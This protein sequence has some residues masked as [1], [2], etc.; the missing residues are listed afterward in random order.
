MR[1]WCFAVL[2]VAC[3]SNEGRRSQ[4]ITRA[5][6]IVAAPAAETGDAV[7]TADA[8]VETGP[9][10]R[11]YEEEW[12]ERMTP[13]ITTLAHPNRERDRATLEVDQVEETWILRWKNLPEADG[14]TW[15]ACP[16]RIAR[17][18]E[19]GELQL[20]RSRPGSADEILDLKWF[21]P[22]NVARVRRYPDRGDEFFDK[23]TPELAAQIQERPAIRLLEFVDYDHDGRATEFLLPVST[24]DPCFQD[25]AVVVGISRSKP[26]LH[27]FSTVERPRKPLTFFF[28]RHGFG[29]LAKAPHDT[30]V[31]ASVFRCGSHGSTIE[32]V[33]EVRWDDDGLH[34]RQRTFGC[35]PSY[36]RGAPIDDWTFDGEGL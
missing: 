5:P 16:D 23:P 2:L 17:Y 15:T 35:T 11:S 9:G 3:R 33:T 18:G 10:P 8:V 12:A 20:V 34:R 27:A 26:R 13:V 7:T 31:E 22:E 19:R 14:W 29:E 6:E 25:R 32:V 36:E 28:S 24:G 30:W 21:F 4:P 1:A